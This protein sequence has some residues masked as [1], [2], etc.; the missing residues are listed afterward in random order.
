MRY[1]VWAACFPLC[2]QKLTFITSIRFGTLGSKCELA[3]YELQLMNVC[4]QTS[5]KSASQFL[6]VPP[7]EKSPI[8]R[9]PKAGEIGFPNS[10][11][12]FALSTPV[13]SFHTPELVS[14][15]FN[16]PSVF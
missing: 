12:I 16:S 8:Y 1:S 4:L 11:N 5:S 10:S 14:N 2:S 6:G 7:K 15:A 13:V 9:Y 3:N